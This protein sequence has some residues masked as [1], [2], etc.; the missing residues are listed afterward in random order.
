MRFEDFPYKK[1]RADFPI[2]QREVYGKPLVYLDNGATTQ[3]PQCVID[4]ITRVYSE[5]N[6]NIH[7]GVHR[8]SQES[9]ELYEEARQRIADYLGV[10]DSKQVIFTSG[11]TEAINLVAQTLGASYFKAGDAILV[12]EMEHHSNLVSWQLV[13]Q[14][15]GLEVRKLPVGDDGTIALEDLDRLL[16][17]RVRLVAVTH[18]S[19][20]LGVVNP[21]RAMADMAHAR[22]ALI[23]VDGAQGVK[24]GKPRLPELGCD[25]YA[26]SGHKLYGPNGIGVLWGRAE[27]MEA[28][29]PWKGGGE[30]VG[31]V[32]FEGT[33]YAT[34]PHRLEAG[35]PPYV[36]A[37]ALGKA[38]EYY[39]PMAEE[40]TAYETLLLH[41]A[42][43]G[44]SA[45][46]ELEIFGYNPQNAAILSF[47]PRGAHP[48][49]LGVLLDK[50]GIAVRTGTHCAEPLMRRLGTTGTARASFAFYN[51]PE[52]VDRL[53][54]GAKRA[55]RMLLPG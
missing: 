38:V 12:S 19:N 3:K 14:Q 46:P 16:D 13:A 5:C 7:R 9:T 30:M 29:P 24:H 52:E 53:V 1:W 42:Y 2:L 21:I 4:T 23:L 35:T 31:T 26:F 22:G 45:I 18:V 50:M 32:S 39:G 15:R 6:A 48:Y 10:P 37:I 44:L 11:A 55:V 41:R 54:E 27:L 34:L 49:D 47:I 8:L 25:F 20:V 43:E 51:T 28:L 36:E 40:A 17:K 33:T